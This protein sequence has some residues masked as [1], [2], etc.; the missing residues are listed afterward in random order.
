[1]LKTCT[2]AQINSKGS[3]SNRFQNRWVIPDFLIFFQLYTTCVKSNGKTDSKRFPSADDRAR[4]IPVGD[5]FDALLQRFV[6]QRL[7][8][9]LAHGHLTSAERGRRRVETSLLDLA[10]HQFGPRHLSGGI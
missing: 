9:Q 8:V 5:D 10:G 1:M 6:R 4:Y 7:G 3:I 2:Y